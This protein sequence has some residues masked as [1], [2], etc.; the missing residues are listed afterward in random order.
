[1]NIIFSILSSI[2]RNMNNSITAVKIS[3]VNVNKL[4]EAS[5]LLIFTEKII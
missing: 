1:M 5:D 3:S 2:W 4:Q